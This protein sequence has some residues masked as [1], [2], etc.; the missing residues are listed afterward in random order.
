LGIYKIQGLRIFNKL[1]QK[2]V[3]FNEL[4]GIIIEEQETE[5]S[6]IDFSH[7]TESLI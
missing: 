1:N 4:P 3:T 2:E 5:G 6:K 7:E